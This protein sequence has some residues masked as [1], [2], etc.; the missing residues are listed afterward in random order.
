MRGI[1]KL[2]KSEAIRLKHTPLLWVHLI[3][4][5]LGAAVF[6]GYYSFSG[7]GSAAKVQAYL[8]VVSCSWPFLCGIICALAE[9]MEAEG[10]WQNFLILPQRKYQALLAKWLVLLVAGFM[11]CLLA[12]VGLAAVYRFFPEG[13]VFPFS[14]YL[15]E[16][17]LI[18]MG[19][20]VVYL[21]HLAL[22]L[23]FGKTVSIGVGTAGSLLAFLML[24]GLGD[25]IW[26]FF[27]WA[28]SC[29]GCSY[30]LL[31]A[32]GS[33][34]NFTLNPS[35]KMGGIFCLVMDVMKGFGLGA[36]DYIRKP[37]G[38]GELRARVQAHIRREKR[39]K[40]NSVTVGDVRF[41]LKEK[42]VEA[43]GGEIVLTPGEYAICEFLALHRGQVFSREQ[44]Y[45]KVFGYGGESDDSAITEHVKNIRGKFRK[46]GLSPIE[47]VWGI[48]YKWKV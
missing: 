43:G 27:P 12:V 35:V 26:M 7:W 47:T 21:L 36:D 34:P 31:Y 13:T 25:G 48:G 30:L 40:K 38:V 29:R 33:G 8:Q 44:I 4:P 42:R 14:V 5:L 28:W 19:Q 17:V 46:A 6:L 39:E 22:S 23:R 32:A 3:V 9:E 16:A 18:W 2:L 41:Y 20:A 15:Q 1:W 11:A 37:F 45:E 24:T 10:G